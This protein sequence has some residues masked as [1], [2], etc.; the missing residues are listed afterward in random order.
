MAMVKRVGM[1]KA[2]DKNAG[3][4]WGEE[5]RKINKQISNWSWTHIPPFIPLK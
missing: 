2:N 5:K 1:D 3:N 4:R